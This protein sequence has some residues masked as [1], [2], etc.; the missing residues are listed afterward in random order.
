MR[1][2]VKICGIT[3]LDDALAAV[4]AGADALGF[5]FYPESPRYVYPESVREI[6]GYLP[7]MIT[8]TGVFV[9]E[10]IEKVQ[11]ISKYC[12]L[13]LLQFHGK[14]SPEYCQWHGSR[15]MK[16]FRVR[17][18]SVIDEMKRYEVSGY[19]L[20]TYAQ[21]VHGG[22]GICFDWSLARAAA[23]LKPVVLAGGLTPDNVTE[24]IEKVR[25]YAV[26]VSSGVEGKPGKKAAEKIF[27]F[28]KAVEKADARLG[29]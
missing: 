25:P 6:V 5:V 9:N 15:V 29:S 1:T 26:D 13:S 10:H 22:T 23:D 20:D 3:N 28:I 8:V 17:D 18:A 2:R 16:A 7:P 21:D 14:E 4:E 24:A 27:N 11:E 12:S 19:L